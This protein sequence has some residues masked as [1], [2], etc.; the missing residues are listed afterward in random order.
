MIK[1]TKILGHGGVCPFQL[2]AL[3]DDNRRIYG[4]YRGGHLRVYVSKTGDLTEDGAIDGDLYFSNLIGGRYDG[5]I[6]LEEFKYFT[7]SV[8]D[9]SEAVDEYGPSREAML[10]KLKA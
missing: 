3:T 10:I 9:W 6:S 8:I 4:R 1:I 7:F 5:Y 2:D